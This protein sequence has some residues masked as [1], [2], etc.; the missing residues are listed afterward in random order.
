[1]VHLKTVVLAWIFNAEVI[2]YS[3]GFGTPYTQDERNRYGGS[4][5]TR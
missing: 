3:V 2:C 4:L 1:M 5:V